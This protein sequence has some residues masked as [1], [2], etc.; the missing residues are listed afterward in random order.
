MEDVGHIGFR[1]PH[2]HKERRNLLTP[3]DLEVLSC[4]K[5]H[6]LLPAPVDVTVIGHEPAMELRAGVHIVWTDG[7]GK[8]KRDP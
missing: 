3:D 2:R 5:L 4:L 8:R 7:S 1:C 6:G